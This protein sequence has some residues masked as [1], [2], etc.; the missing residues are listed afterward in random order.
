MKNIARAAAVLAL[1]LVVV[2]LCGLVFYDVDLAG[3]LWTTVVSNASEPSYD[4]VPV[5][6]EPG[7]ST[8][9]YSYIASRMGYQQLPEEAAQALYRQMEDAVSQI[10]PEPDEDGLYPIS[11][12]VYED[13]RIDESQIHMVV[14]AFRNENP[15]VFWLAN[16]YRYVYRGDTTTV[17]LYSYVSAEECGKMTEE[18]NLVRQE[19][20]AGLQGEMSELDRELYLFDSLASRCSY[21]TE[22]A[23]NGENWKAYTQYGALVDGKAVCEG[24][25]RAMQSL[26]SCAGLESTLVSGTSKGMLHMWNLVKIDGDWYHLDATWND[27]DSLVS[28]KYFN[29]TDEMI[30][31]DHAVFPSYAELTEGEYD[32]EDL[33]NAN[34]SLPACT[35]S[36]ANYYLAKA[37]RLET[38]EWRTDGALKNEIASAAKTGKESFS[39][40]IGPELDFN[41]ALDR[42]FSKAPYLVARCVKEVSQETGIAL[43]SNR[44]VFVSDP[45]SRGVTI[46]L[47]Y[48]EQQ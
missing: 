38:I 14:S 19:I 47:L 6:Q 41:E 13:G 11:E 15:E 36:D 25:A 32:A 3:R 21:D 4:P 44:S 29:V 48:Q 46:K 34:L 39:V 23:S 9:H 28:Y 16:R 20:F 1:L 5:S 10:A 7:D 2:Q 22:A 24:Y 31:E 45:V 33:Q 17:R 37:V 43:E 30:G 35:A 40:Y 18:L 26:L 42:L 12:V 27:S 8:P